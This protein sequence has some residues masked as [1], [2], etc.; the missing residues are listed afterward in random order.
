M[1]GLRRVRAPGEVSM[2]VCPFCGE[3]IPLRRSFA[4]HLPHCEEYPSG[5]EG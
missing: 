4:D 2:D 1:M 5:G 3:A